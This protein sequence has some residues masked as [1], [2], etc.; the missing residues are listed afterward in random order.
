MGGAKFPNKDKVGKGPT[1]LAVGADW[2]G[3]D[4]FS[5][6][7]LSSYFSP[8]KALKNIAHLPDNEN[9]STPEDVLHISARRLYVD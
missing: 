2:G 6:P 9:L 3:L 7:V 8:N 5:L 4:I 1:V